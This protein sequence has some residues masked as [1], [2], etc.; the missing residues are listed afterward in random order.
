[1]LQIKNETPFK[2]GMAIFPDA[3]GVDTL[4]VAIRA[5]FTMAGGKL[6]VA[7]A[8]PPVRLADEYRGEPGTSSLTHAADLHLGKPTTDVALLGEAWAPGGK[9]APAVD[10]SLS[11]GPVHKVV[12]VFGERE[13]SGLLGSSISAPVPF[14]KIPLLYERAFGGVLSY[15]E[16]KDQSILDWRNPVGVG[17]GK[18]K[19]PGDKARRLLP[20][21][22]DP[23]HLLKSPR[24]RPPPAGFG[25]IAPSW[26]PRRSLG[27]TY[28]EAWQTRRA[29]YLPKDF[30]PRFFNAA[31]PDLVSKRYLR[32]GELV[33]VHNASPSPLRFNLPACDLDL[34]VRIDGATERPPLTLQTV[35]IEPSERKLGLVWLGALGCD[36]KPL[37]VSEVK[38]GIKRLDLEGRPA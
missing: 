32:G 11:V 7:E 33:Q 6:A 4:Y 3:D 19:A 20:N 25:F 24:D 31:H 2:I 36:K 1:M 10:V 26:E 37:K 14:E 29:P 34:A 12:R 38:I 16:S 23:A 13:W 8:Q 15:D 28:D 18:R 22:E 35:V 21:L 30:Q 17:P 5:T 9:S 27:G